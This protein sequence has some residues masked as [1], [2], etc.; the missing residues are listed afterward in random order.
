MKSV[1]DIFFIFCYK[2]SLWRI[3]V[4]LIYCSPISIFLRLVNWP[5]V[6]PKISAPT[7]EILFL[8][9]SKRLK[10]NQLRSLVL[11]R[12]F[13]INQRYHNPREI[14]SNSDNFFEASP[15]C[16]RASSL[17][18]LSL[19]REYLFVVLLLISHKICV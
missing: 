9:R 13:Y 6:W 5:R 3:N 12:E 16:F 14:F 15:K 1:R 18:W 4:S 10:V 7:S 17:I 11:D 19:L 2:F 8:L